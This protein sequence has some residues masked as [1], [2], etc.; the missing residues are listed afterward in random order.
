MSLIK[1]AFF[2]GTLNQTVVHPREIF[3]EA[4]KL[5]AHSIILVHNHPS[6]DST[7]SKADFQVTDV[8]LDAAEII[9][10]PIADHIIIGDHEYYSIKFKRKNKYTKK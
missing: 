10:I 6:G 1:N 4:I 7:A 2:V 3:N 8:L 5:M 9:G